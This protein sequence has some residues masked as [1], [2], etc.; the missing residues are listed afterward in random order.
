MYML[1]DYD[2]HFVSA[3]I[4]ILASLFGMQYEKENVVETKFRD[5]ENTSCKIEQS[6]SSFLRTLK[7]NTDLLACK[8]EYYNQCGE[9]QKCFELTSV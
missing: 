1:I 8:A 2:G 6:N 7:T 9:Y 4:L 5:L 3:C